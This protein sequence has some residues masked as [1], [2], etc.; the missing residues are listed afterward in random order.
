[1]NSTK[2]R[3]SYFYDTNIGKF[4]YGG[5]HP[6]KPKRIRLTHDLITGYGLHSKMQICPINHTTRKELCKFHSLEYIQFLES[7]TPDNLDE[8]T[9]KLDQFNIGEDVPIFDGVLEFSQ[10]SAGGS[11]DGAR[12][13]NHGETD[14]AIN[15]SGGLHHAKSK[16]ASGFCY[17][18]DIVL[19]IYELLKYH[20]RILY[21]DIDIH[22][23]DGVEDAFYQTNRVMTCSFHKYGNDFFP[24]TGK[25]DDIGESL[26]TN[27]AVNVPLKDGMDDES[28][29]ILFK[30]VIDAI[31][32]YYQPSAIVL[33]CGA[34]TLT[35]DKLGTFNLSIKGHGKCVSYVRGLNK[36]LLVLGGGGYTPKNVARCWTYETSLLICDIEL[37]NELPLSAYSFEFPKE[38]SLHIEP[39]STLKNQN[40][41]KNLNRIFSQIYQNLKQTEPVPSVGKREI[42]H[43][44]F[45]SQFELSDD[46]DE[47]D[48]EIETNER[49]NSEQD[50]FSKQFSWQNSRF[51]LVFF[52]KDY[53]KKDQNLQVIE[54]PKLI[55]KKKEKQKNK[56]KSLSSQ[57]VE[58][59]CKNKKKIKS[60]KQFVSTQ[61]KVS[62]SKVKSELKSNA[63]L[64]YELQLQCKSETKSI[65]TI[66]NDKKINLI[67]HIKSE[68]KTIPIYQLNPNPQFERKHII[69][70][71]ENSLMSAPTL[72]K[73]Q[74][75]LERYKILQE[76]NQFK[77][78]I[79]NFKTNEQKNQK[80]CEDQINDLP[81]PI[82]NY[83]ILSRKKPLQNSK[84]SKVSL[85]SRSD[86]S[87]NLQNNIERNIFN[88]NKF[89]ITSQ[90]KK[91]IRKNSKTKIE[92]KI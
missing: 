21:I 9:E 26:G 89:K 47:Y 8:F 43:E 56:K 66:Q 13:L 58:L 84:K 37:E 33:Q 2:K 90:D 64:E 29:F 78:L 92:E 57:D 31:M 71:K 91:R 24:G 4:N 61:E 53:S 68:E 69:Y 7:I 12:K 28:Y 36:P 5:E 22:H 51:E 88:H 75:K 19:G 62:K 18:N 41:K 45:R 65:N 67:N 10:I 35:R 1:M 48:K 70:Q 27:Y 25:L 23:G 32:V 63:K 82:K 85:I 74:M 11:I 38:T 44:I 73:I 49:Y 3:V 42:P 86:I 80:R 15:W 79:D 52:E 72:S 60:Q 14:I 81:I 6:M 40:D 55:F 87:N 83:P 76:S 59:F 77:N 46:E 50:I 17:I 20:S 16:E 54:E 34:D 39:S 30:K